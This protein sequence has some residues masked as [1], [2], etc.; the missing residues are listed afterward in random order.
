MN[1]RTPKIVGR[2]LIR[3]DVE[4]RCRCGRLVELAALVEPAADGEDLDLIC[5]HCGQQ[6]GKLKADQA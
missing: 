5:V 6:L 2:L 1:E 4:F 3:P